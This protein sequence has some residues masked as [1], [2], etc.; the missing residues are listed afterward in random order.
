MMNIFHISLKEY[1]SVFGGEVIQSY[2]LQSPTEGSQSKNAKMQ[3][4]NLKAGT[5]EEPTR[6]L[7]ILLCDFLTLIGL[8]TSCIL[9]W[10]HLPRDDS[11]HSRVDSSISLTHQENVP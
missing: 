11:T 2:S 7:Q 6:E 1:Y 9:T 3:S 4:R 5:E 8:A 10:P